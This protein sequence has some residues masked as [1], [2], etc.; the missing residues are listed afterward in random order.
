M[1]K[2]KGY[3][4]PK[5]RSQL[6]KRLESINVQLRPPTLTR[7][8][9][10]GIPSLDFAIRGMPVDRVVQMYGEKSSGK[11][12]LAMLILRA[13][14]QRGEAVAWLD[15]ERSLT[16]DYCDLLGIPVDAMDQGEPLLDRYEATT[17]EEWF[18]ALR[19][20][21]ASRRY[22]LIVID[23]LA[24]FAPR[25]EMES[26]SFDK[27]HMG[28]FPRLVSKFW[29]VMGASLSGADCTILVIN[30]ERMDIGNANAATGFVPKTPPGGKAMEH[31]SALTLAMMR[32]YETYNEQAE[33]VERLNF[34]FKIEKSKLFPSSPKRQFDV[35][36]A[37][38]PKRYD[39]D[40]SYET[41]LLA[42]QLGLFTDKN[43][44]A[45]VNRVAFFEGEKVAD[46]EQNIIAFFDTESTL[47]DRIQE[48]IQ[49]RLTGEKPA[50]AEPTLWADEEEDS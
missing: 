12:T 7:Y 25:A 47:K 50:S 2:R 35:F 18:D 32:P 28:L 39:V 24:K 36:L 45:W 21:L 23:S 29:R 9:S 19:D 30:Q 14:L 48:A 37:C 42:K 10:T 44:E 5:T 17:A 33:R 4:A 49:L 22:K 40:W 43:G 20:A 8:R 6:L 34:R 38:T 41:F 26:A 3:E 46:G 1:D 11:S 16:L 13:Y 27:Q 31:E 15:A